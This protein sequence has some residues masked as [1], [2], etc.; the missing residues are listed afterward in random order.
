MLNLK[1]LKFA[2]WGL[3]VMFMIEIF[4]YYVCMLRIA[5]LYKFEYIIQQ[6]GKDRTF[7]LHGELVKSSIVL[8]S[9][10]VIILISMIFLINKYEELTGKPSNTYRGVTMVLTVF[11]ILFIAIYISDL[12]K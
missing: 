11:H 9:A 8:F 2:I 4:A 6:T 12:N 10:S 1:K 3:S 7:S 5:L